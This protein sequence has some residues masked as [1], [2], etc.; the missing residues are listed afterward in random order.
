MAMSWEA[1]ERGDGHARARAC[2]GG[3]ISWLVLAT[4]VL[5]LATGSIDYDSPG[6]PFWRPLGGSWLLGFALIAAGLAVLTWCG[7][8]LAVTTR[9]APLPGPSSAEDLL[10]WRY[11]AG[12][13]SR[14]QYQEMAAVLWA[15]PE[16]YPRMEVR[17]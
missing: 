13:L 1:Q 3:R 10:R 6:W 16:A 4:V 9:A 7:S 5:L 17:A 14:E 2:A 11:A 12:E 15:R 8:T